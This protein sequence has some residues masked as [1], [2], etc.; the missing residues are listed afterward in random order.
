MN[1]HV[2]EFIEGPSAF[3]RFREA[4]KHILTVPKNAVPSPF[5]K[6]ALKKTAPKGKP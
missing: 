5:K 3:T 4:V 1:V 2:T 6:R